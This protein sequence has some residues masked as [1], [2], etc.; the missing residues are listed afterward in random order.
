[1]MSCLFICAWYG[2]SLQMLET[3][4]SPTLAENREEKRDIRHAPDLLDGPDVNE[5]GKLHLYI[6]STLCKYKV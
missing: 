4:K 5:D 2:F 3:C 6:L 1:M